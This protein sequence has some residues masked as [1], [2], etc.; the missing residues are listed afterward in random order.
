MNPK[1]IKKRFFQIPWVEKKLIVRVFILLNVSRFFTF[2]IPLKQMQF[3]FQPILLLKRRNVLSG[4]SKEKIIWAIE[5]V[6]AHSR[7]AENCLSKA[8][9]AQALFLE[10]GHASE[11][12]IGVSK[13]PSASLEAHAWMESGGRVV[14]GESQK[15]EHFVPIYKALNR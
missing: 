3:L 7:F 12:Y 4:I 8:L 9:V 5:S 2:F 15:K 11:L 1:K 10:S 13:N 14:L 6:S